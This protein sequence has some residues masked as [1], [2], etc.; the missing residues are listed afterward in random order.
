[1]RVLN[2]EESFVVTLARRSQ[3][4]KKLHYLIIIT[5]TLFKLFMLLFLLALNMKYY[6]ILFLYLYANENYVILE[7]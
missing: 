7:H 2:E 4:H 1:M 3:K 6:P 5:L